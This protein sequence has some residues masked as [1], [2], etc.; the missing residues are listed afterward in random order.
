MSFIS[1]ILDKFKMEST[2]QIELGA[3]GSEQT[4]YFKNGKMYRVSP[5]DKESWYDARYLASDGDVYDLEN[6]E[7]IKRIPVPNFDEHD[8]MM[9]GYGVT[10]SLD[11]VI[12][13]K[14]GAF[15]NR[16][17]KEL[18]S[19]CLWKSTELMFENKSI[20]WQ[21]KDF[22][23]LVNWHNELGMYDEAEKAINYLKKHNQ[24]TENTFDICASQIK[25]SIFNNAK[26]FGCD[27]VAFN[28]YGAGCCEECAKMRGRVYSISGNS[29][30]FPP[31]PLYAKKHGNFH[32]GC[33]C[34]MSIFFADDDEIFYKGE[35]QNAIKVSNRAWIDDRDKPE[36]ELYNN[37]VFQLEE[38][39]KK[40][41]DRKEYYSIQKSFPE[42]APKSFGA[43]RRMKN[44]KS[45]NFLKIVDAAKEKGIEIKMND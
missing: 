15:Y 25:D 18:C 26:Q 43:Y 41:N 21:K 23:R 27:L 7:D 8:T 38:N 36:I 17:Q 42:F 16:N 40:E 14:A 9:D 28:D 34:T 33:R 11:Y 24:Y 29:K 12:R 19:A 13:M 31:L 37:Y 35:K 5:T 45:N 32:P 10:G 20:S 39:E 4:I 44:T 30:K 2:R 3:D 1:A 22:E 6:V